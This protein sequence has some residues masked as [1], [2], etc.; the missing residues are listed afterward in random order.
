MATS[1]L[2]EKPTPDQYGFARVVSAVGLESPTRI[3]I[4]PVKLLKG[5]P[6][7]PGGSSGV[8]TLWAGDTTIEVTNEACDPPVLKEKITIPGAATV[9]VVVYHQ[10]KEVDGMLVPELKFSKLSESEARQEPQL[11]VV[12]L[13]A[14]PEVPVTVGRETVMLNR[15]RAKKFDA[16]L[17]QTVTIT[18]K[19]EAIENVEMRQGGHYVVFLYDDLSN[20][21]LRAVAVHFMKYEIDPSE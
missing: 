7:P 21:G 18:Y 17:K 14:K 2:A 5:N 20:D 9:G 3:T 12:S 8:I 11:S 19:G 4:G 6:V 10:F 15:Q 1:S 16:K 13:S